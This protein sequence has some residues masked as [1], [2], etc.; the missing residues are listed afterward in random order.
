M[1][2]AEI[3]VVIDEL[4]AKCPWL[5]DCTNRFDVTDY[6]AESDATEY[7][8]A[9]IGQEQDFDEDLS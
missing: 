7:I 3:Y 1:T 5:K 2:Y 6:M 8:F 4:L 9:S